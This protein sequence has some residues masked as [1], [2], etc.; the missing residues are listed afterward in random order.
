VRWIGVGERLLHQLDVENATAVAFGVLAQRLVRGFGQ[1]GVGPRQKKRNTGF[2]FD[3][4]LLGLQ[5]QADRPF[6]VSLP[7]LQ[8]P[9]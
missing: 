7:S 9:A 1:R 6:L 8:G 3:A 4:G 2:R 5:T